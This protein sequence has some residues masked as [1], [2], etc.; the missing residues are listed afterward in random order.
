[1][2]ATTPLLAL[3]APGPPDAG[4]DNQWLTRSPR[5][6]PGAAPWERNG[7]SESGDVEKA[8][9]TGNHTDGVTVADLI[10]KVHGASSVPEELRRTRPE[11]EPEPV[12]QAP[13][14]EVIAAVH[15]DSGDPDTEV[16]PVVAGYASDLPDLARCAGATGCSRRAS[17]P[18]VAR[19]SPSHVGAVA[20]DDGRRTRRR[21]PDRG[22]GAGADRWG[23]AVAVVEE[24]HAQQGLRAGPR[25]AR[26]PR[27]QR[28]VR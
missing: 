9:Q 27:P 21:R 14:T 23:V 26:H 12:P 20:E 1:M 15:V 11:P 17:G 13:P 10:A 19:A 7:I 5:P 8:E 4:G 18:A 16:I 28:P 24:Q 22:V 3:P 25:L 6:S 2:T